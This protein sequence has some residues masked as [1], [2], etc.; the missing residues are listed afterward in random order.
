MVWGSDTHEKDSE[1]LKQLNPPR[2]LNVTKPLQEKKSSADF[3]HSRCNPS[4]LGGHFVLD[5]ESP[6]LH[7]G[8]TFEDST[9]KIDKKYYSNYAKTNFILSFS[10]QKTLPL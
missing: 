10:Y 3:S 5:C 4:W 8:E 1:F 2:K 6:F 7:F 9:E